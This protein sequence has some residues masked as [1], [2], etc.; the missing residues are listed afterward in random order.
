[1]DKHASYHAYEQA[2]L[3]LTQGDLQFGRYLLPVFYAI[4]LDECIIEVSLDTSGSEDSLRLYLPSGQLRIWDS[5]Q[6]CCES[7]YMTTDDELGSFM[8]AK[9]IGLDIVEVPTED[10]E[11]GDPHEQVFVKLE[12]NMGAITLVTHN[13]HNG[14]YGGF[15]VVS[16]WE[17]AH[18]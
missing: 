4:S 5:G 13:E 12:T 7:R 11:H 18:G 1:M 6:S 8:G 2:I 9:L 14:Y 15:H 16:S 3:G 10:D 17:E